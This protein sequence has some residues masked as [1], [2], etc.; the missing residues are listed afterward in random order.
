MGGGGTLLSNN[1]NASTAFATPATTT[2]ATTPTPTT[3]AVI[4]NSETNNTD[5]IPRL[6]T[7]NVTVFVELKAVA[8]AAQYVVLPSEISTEKRIHKDRMAILDI[9]NGL[10]EAVGIPVGSR[11]V[12]LIQCLFPDTYSS[13]LEV[14][15]GD[16]ELLED[17]IVMDADADLN[18]D[19]N[20]NINVDS[21]ENNDEKQQEAK[22]TLDVSI[23]YLRRVHLMPFYNGCKGAENIGCILGG[24]HPAGVVHR[25]QQQQPQQQ[26]LVVVNNTNNTENVATMKNVEEE[27]DNEDKDKDKENNANNNNNDMLI[28]DDDIALDEKGVV[29]QQK[30][31]EKKSTENSAATTT[32]T[33]TT[34]ATTNI[35]V[36][37]LDN[38]IAKAR[39]SI[40]GKNVENIS[41]LVISNTIKTVATEIDTLEK[42]SKINWI[43][44]HTLLDHDGRARCSFHFCRK[45][46][47]DKKF[48]QK[49]LV[50]KHPEFLRAEVAKCHDSYMMKGWD[51]EVNRPVPP[52]LVDCG[53]SFGLVPSPVT[54]SKAPSAVD[55]EPGLWSERRERQRR[56]E[57]EAEIRRKQRADAAELEE[58]QRGLNS[59]DLRGGRGGGGI[60]GDRTDE[61]SQPSVSN[62]DGGGGNGGSFLDVD[63]MK[64]EKVEL[65]FENVNVLAPPPKKKR[66]KKRKKL[67]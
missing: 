45:L 10:D 57:A 54:G 19:S 58:M 53:S 44:N 49:H 17:E 11:L 60:G 22:D 21:N 28:V 3:A 2:T 31:V 61:R 41:S 33:T 6:P 23:A 34:T 65:S 42:K 46:F 64:D 5:V 9:A 66:K 37:R 51:L 25:R 67:L 4:T 8:T 32:T 63:D 1:G 18:T 48:L 55:P 14:G 56:L 39:K 24:C 47:K 36:F 52:I 29:E 35:V 12:D 20:A 30:E 15:V 38:S 50:K 27:E 7:R 40:K 43:E 13:L 62:Q 59:G 26:Q 16:S